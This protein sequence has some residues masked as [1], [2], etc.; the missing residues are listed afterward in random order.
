MA[1]R[2]FLCYN[3][4]YMLFKRLIFTIILVII[5]FSS[6]FFGI[7]TFLP[8]VNPQNQNTVE[9]EEDTGEETTREETVQEDA[10][11]TTPQE[12]AV[13]RDNIITS[14]LFPDMDAEK[15]IQKELS[16]KSRQV[17]G[18]WATLK[19]VNG[20][21]NVLQSAQVGGSFFVEA[22]VNPLEF[23]A[24]LDN[25]LDKISDMLL[26]AFAA[27]T[28]EKILLAVSGYLIFIL[29]IP[30]CAIVSIVSLWTTKEKSRIHRVLIVTVI[31]SLV[32][33]F[34]VPVSFQ[35]SALMEQ[36]ILTNN[37]SR[38][39]ASIE[40][41]NDAASG[42]EN[43]IN[44]LR[45]IGRTITNYMTSVKD[46]G[47]A[48]IEDMINYFIIFIFTNIFIPIFTILGLFFLVRY[49]AKVILRD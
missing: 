10:E 20:I 24:P 29:I 44:S 48:V 36:K 18:V 49:C 40:E 14:F 19:V 45:R 1:K 27:I 2:V 16:D 9:T 32:I 15:G 30:V 12:P 28:F 39:L 41:K 8:P 25:I 5:F 43:E 47:N 42:M 3:Q 21:V 23:L 38:V 7:R 6:F 22:S 37:V 46:L 17:L 4:C 26:W 33:P 11:E 34:A 13:R 31:I 35:L